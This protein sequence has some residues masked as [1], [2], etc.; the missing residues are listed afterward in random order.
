MALLCCAPSEIEW[1]ERIGESNL[2]SIKCDLAGISLERLAEQTNRTMSKTLATT[3]AFLCNAA[4]DEAGQPMQMRNNHGKYTAG[5]RAIM[6][7]DYHNPQRLSYRFLAL[8]AEAQKEKLTHVQ[9]AAYGMGSYAKPHVVNMP[10][11]PKAIGSLTWRQRRDRNII[12]WR[13]DKARAIKPEI[14]G[15]KR[16]QAMFRKSATARHG[17]SIKLLVDCVE[18]QAP[19]LH[20]ASS[21][22]MIVQQCNIPMNTPAGQHI[23][24]KILRKDDGEAAKASDAMFQ[25][26]LRARLSEMGKE[27][28]RCNGF[29][30]SEEK[31]PCPHLACRKSS[32]VGSDKAY[33]SAT[34]QVTGDDREEAEMNA[35]AQKENR[36]AT[37]TYCAPESLYDNDTLGEKISPPGIN[38]DGIDAHKVDPVSFNRVRPDSVYKAYI[39]GVESYILFPQAAIWRESQF[40]TFLT[41]LADIIVEVVDQ[42][43]FAKNANRNARDKSNGK[44]RFDEAELQKH[45]YSNIFSTLLHLKL[46]VKPGYEYFNMVNTKILLPGETTMGGDVTDFA[47]E[48]LQSDR[49]AMAKA[50]FPATEASI[51]DP[52]KVEDFHANGGGQKSMDHSDYCTCAQVETELFLRRKNCSRKCISAKELTSHPFAKIAERT[53]ILL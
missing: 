23:M 20:I 3:I 35:K 16:P 42:H 46:V 51:V 39:R 36:K 9:E 38:P 19:A 50:S 7:G 45:R 21:L 24:R 4:K 6:W 25:A 31:I 47:T 8:M 29:T 48:L 12:A 5:H 28:T 26:V 18:V 53:T 30:D 49:E 27:P 17:R 11:L 15:A 43:G 10:A 40:G 34:C 13:Q 14:P 32:I 41:S 33:C 1:T 2:D 37:I 52:L 22:S 44:M